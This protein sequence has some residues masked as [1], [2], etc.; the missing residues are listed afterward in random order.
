[1]RRRGFCY[2]TAD[3]HIDNRSV[4]RRNGGYFT[5]STAAGEQMLSRKRQ[6]LSPEIAGETDLFDSLPD[7]LV[8]SILC[9]LSSSASCPS[10]F[11]NVLITYAFL[12]LTLKYFIYPFSDAD[13]RF[14]FLEIE[15]P[16]CRNSL[17]IGVLAI[18]V[19]DIDRANKEMIY[20]GI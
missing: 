7:D 10:D 20:F 18:E 5:T 4:K 11:S 6:K 19:F 13:F 9:K 2:P 16:G 15:I 17:R 12:L 14:P 8:L 1:M 3:D